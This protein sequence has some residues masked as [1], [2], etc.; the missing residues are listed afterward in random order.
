MDY[1]VEAI[2]QQPERERLQKQK[3]KAIA[4]TSDKYD[5]ISGNH[6]HDLLRSSPVRCKKR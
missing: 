6:K 4:R 1:L 2:M 3:E 5:R